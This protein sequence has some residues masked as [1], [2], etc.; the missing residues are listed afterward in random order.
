MWFP[1]KFVRT[2]PCPALGRPPS[3]FPRLAVEALEDRDVPA[4]LISIDDTAVVEGNAGVANLVYN[5]RLSQLAATDVYYSISVV[6]TKSTAALLLDYSL[7][8]FNGMIPVGQTTG[9]VTVRVVGDL[10]V[11]P[12]ETVVLHLSGVAN[13][14]I[15]DDEAVGTIVNDDQPPPAAVR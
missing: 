12:D 8:S 15:A 6:P 3:A 13:A 11:E 2:R 10:E 9:S 4:A 7:T 5:V 1:F 14:T